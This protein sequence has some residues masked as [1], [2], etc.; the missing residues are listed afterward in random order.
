[1]KGDE[2]RRLAAVMDACL[3]KP[4]RASELYVAIEQQGVRTSDEG[5]AGLNPRG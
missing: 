4:V 3:S 5:Y 1:L 2:G